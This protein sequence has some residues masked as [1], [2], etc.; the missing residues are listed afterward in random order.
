[1]TRNPKWKR[2]EVILALDL[3]FRLNPSHINNNHDEITKLSS[4]LNNMHIHNEVEMQDNFRN[5]NGVYMKLCNFLPFDPSYNG[6]GLDA[7]SKLD[8]VIWDEFSGDL[9]RL[10]SVAESIKASL[11]LDGVKGYERLS[12]DEEEFLEGQILYRR[13]RS[14]E[15][16]AKLIKRAKKIAEDKGNICCEVCGFDFEKVYGEIGKGYIECH[17]KIPVSEYEADMKTKVSDLALVCSNCHR[18][19]HR[20]RPWLKAEDLKTLTMQ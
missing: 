19:L 16:N 5:N 8:K 11:I 7:G 18:M 15:R 20:K 12:D 10:S 17:H 3:Y 1:L 6:K 2:D 14:I 4:I 9:S 13:H